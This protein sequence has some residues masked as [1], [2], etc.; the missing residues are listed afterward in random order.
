MGL[1]DLI[2]LALVAASAQ[3]WLF[4][5]RTQTATSD[6]REVEQTCLDK[7][8][9]GDC[10]F[11][12]C[13]ERRLPCGRDGYMVRHGQYYCNKM[14]REKPTFS[15]EGQNFLDDAKR[16]M[17]QRL[18]EHYQREYTDCHDLEHDAIGS[19]S[20]CFE[21]FAFCNVFRDESA[22]FWNIFEF[23]DLFRRGAGKIWRE[24]FA[25]TRQCSAVYLRD[26]SSQAGQSISESINSMV[27]TLSEAASDHSE[28][29]IEALNDVFDN[30]SNMA[31][32]GRRAIEGAL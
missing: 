30:L 3:A 26:I 22:K 19:I 23:S 9:A 29:A 12:E 31:A 15:E 7:A 14:E 32:E 8:D 25:L 2:V 10:G 20:D 17:M 28:T 5:E 24:I 4:N 27:D 16:C 18:K 1:Y 11:Y 6:D 13:F 21:D